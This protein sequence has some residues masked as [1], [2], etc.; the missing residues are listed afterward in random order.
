MYNVATEQIL[1]VKAPKQAILFKIVMVIACIL[2]ITTIPQMY[3]IGILLSAVFIVFTVIL[4]KYYNAE[5][6]YSLVDNEF[7]VDKIMSR[8]MRKRCGVYNIAKASLIA[9]PDSQA[10]L[11]M[12]QKK[13]RTYNYTSNEGQENIVLVYTMDSSNELVRLILEPNEKMLEAFKKSAPKS[14]YRIEKSV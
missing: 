7:T 5:Y 8:S 9:K 12:E 3:A 6:E 4:F 13:I 11:G 2:A 10:A 14:A 1:K